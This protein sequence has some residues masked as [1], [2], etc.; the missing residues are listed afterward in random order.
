VSLLATREFFAI[1]PGFP[2]LL[3]KECA[4]LLLLV[5]ALSLP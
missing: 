4:H 1:A 5:R 2:P 3:A